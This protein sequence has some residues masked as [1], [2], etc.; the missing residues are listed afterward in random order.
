MKK[1]YLF[2]LFIVP[3]ILAAQKRVDLDRFDFKVQLRSLPNIK[4]DSTYRTY[5]VAV[6]ST[7]LM[8]PF[9]QEI[10]PASTV[11]LESWRKLPQDG[12]LNIQVK[13]EDLLPETVAVK[14]RSVITKDRNGVVTGT[15]ILYYQEVVY[16]FAATAQIIDYKGTHVMDEV[17]A[18]RQ[19]KQV[20]NSPEFGLKALAESYFL[21]NSLTITKDLYRNCVNKAMHYL[22][23]R[24][25]DDFGFA[26][27]T[28]DDFMWV[29]GSRKHPEYEDSRKAFQVIH[30]VLFSMDADK[31]IEAA[32]E[33]LKP[34]IDYFENIKNTYST[35]KKHDRKIR[36]ASYFNLAVLYYYLDNPE[37]MMKEAGGLILNDYHTTAGK[38]FQETALRLKQQ[39]QQSN[40]YTRHFS[41]D[42]TFYKGPNEKTDTVI[43]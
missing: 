22:G 36:Y 34:A 24:I 5:N 30:E 20:Y 32:R 23:E 38:S 29:I 40:I 2:L 43:K 18:N 10:D 7:K 14:E 39:F 11:I 42:P 26:E 8:Q 41:I 31:S 28:T 4:L 6:T 13:L 37:M 19:R 33:K 9:L 25:T 27:V 16:T 21:L 15:K 35:S 3:A 12:H 17:L 1:Y